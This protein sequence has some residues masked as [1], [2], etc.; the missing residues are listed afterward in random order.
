MKYQF[1]IMTFVV[2]MIF[3]LL[4]ID[5]QAHTLKNGSGADVPHAHYGYCGALGCP[6]SDAIY[7]SYRSFSSAD[8]VYSGTSEWNCHGRTFDNRRSWVNEAEYF[9]FAPC[10]IPKKGDVVIFFGP[11]GRTS[12]SETILGSWDGLSTKVM[13][14]YGM[15]GQYRHTLGDSVRAYGSSWTVMR[16]DSIPVYSSLTG[17]IYEDSNVWSKKLYNYEEIMEITKKMPWYQTVI[18][19]QKLYNQDHTK[20]LIKVSGL[21]PQ[22]K[23]ALVKANDIDKKVFILVKDLVSDTHYQIFGEFER[24]ALTHDFI[25]NIEAGKQLIDLAK[26]DQLLKPT[27]ASTIKNQIVRS[28]Q[29]D[30]YY[31]ADRKRG[32]LI[33]FVYQLLDDEEQTKLQEELSRIQFASDREESYFKDNYTRFYL[34]KDYLK[35]VNR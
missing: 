18:E 17:K 29:Q 26:Q 25:V 24:P 5:V 16:F 6:V 14:K 34:N 23:E 21:Q 20:T 1:K 10:V 28:D 11:D 30:T 12:H 32:A 3:L 8:R 33:Y 35:L 19:S 7:E 22:T 15:Q 4:T 31:M 9:L 2:I 27:V 13:S